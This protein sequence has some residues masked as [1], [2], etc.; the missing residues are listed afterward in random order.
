M[1]VIERILGV[2]PAVPAVERIN[3]EITRRPLLPLVGMAIVVLGL[4]L[5]VALTISA[6]AHSDNFSEGPGG[7][8]SAV[9]FRPWFRIALLG[10]MALVLSGI[11]VLLLAIIARIYWLTV[12]QQRFLP[13]AADGRRQ[14]E[15]HAVR[16]K[17]KATTGNGEQ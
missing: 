9:T 2:P 4:V 1:S 7:T 8:L 15:G 16:F 3:D 6:G 14:R 13:V 17:V 12:V 5:I 10:S 11:I